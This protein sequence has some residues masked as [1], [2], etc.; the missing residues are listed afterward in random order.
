MAR[1][2]RTPSPVRNSKAVQKSVA[3]VAPAA[4]TDA[5][6]TQALANSLRTTLINAGLLK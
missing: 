4:A 6:T 3:P 5:T 2:L 1:A